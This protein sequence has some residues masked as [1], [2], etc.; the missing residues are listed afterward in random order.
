MTVP[1][2]LVTIEG[3]ELQTERFGSDD[4]LIVVEHGKLDTRY[5]FTAHAGAVTT[6]LVTP[7]EGQAIVITDIILAGEKRTG[8]TIVVRFNDGTN[9]AGIISPVVNDAPVNL[10]IPFAGRFL[11]WRNASLEFITDTTN[12]VATLTVG[13]FFVGGEKVLSFAD[14]DAER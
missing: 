3:R 2:H 4:H 1:A 5:K 13:Y 11:G 6:L 9:T 8:A 10:H 7:R 14:W 12:Q